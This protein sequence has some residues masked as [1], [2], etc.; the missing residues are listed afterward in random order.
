MLDPWRTSAPTFANEAM[1]PSV[2]KHWSVGWNFPRP[3]EV[4]FHFHR[5]MDKTLQYLSTDNWPNLEEAFGTAKTRKNM[6]QS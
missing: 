6:R 5:G 1:D 2:Q 4:S 3:G